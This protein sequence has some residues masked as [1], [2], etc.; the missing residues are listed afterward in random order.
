MNNLFLSL[1]VRVRAK[2]DAIGDSKGRLRGIEG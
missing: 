2:V 1:L